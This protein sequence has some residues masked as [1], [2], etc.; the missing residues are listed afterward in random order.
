G[1]WLDDAFASGGSAGY[2]HKKMGITARGGWEAVKRHFREMDKDI[3]SEP[4]TVVGIG[5]MSG[6]VFGNGMLLSEQIKLVAAYDHRDIFIDP[7]PDTAKSFKE[8]KRL[9]EMG[10]S[11][12]QD[13][14]TSKLSKGGGI[15][16]RNQ[17]SIT[18]SKA[19]A[20]AI[21]L[22]KTKASPNEIMTAILKADAE[23]LWFG[24]IGTY[25]RATS[26]TDAEVGDRANDP[27]RIT[28]KEVGAKVIGEGANLGLTQR[29]RIEYGLAGGRCNSDA[30]DNSAGVNSSDVEVNIK[31]ALQPALANNTLPRAKRDKLLEAMTESVADLVLRTNYDQ[32][33]TISRAERA[34]TSQLQV[35]NRLMESLESRGL[36]NRAVEFLPDEEEIT[37]R[38]A[39]GEALTRAEIGVLLSYAK[40]VLF[41]DIVA[42][43]LP[44][45]PYLEDALISY[46]PPRMQKAHGALIAGHR[47]RR[48]IIATLLANQ[49]I[50]RGGT[51]V[52]SR[53]EDATGLLPSVISR[54]HV[55]IRDGLETEAIHAAIDAL[56]NKASGEA[57]LSLYA[58]LAE[59]TRQAIAH[60]L[61]ALNDTS[62]LAEAVGEVAKARKALA[63]HLKK[64]LPP[65]LVDWSAD[66]V[67]EFSDAGLPKGQAEALAML[68]INALIPDL[69][70]VSRQCGAE[71]LPAA[72]AFFEV[73]HTFKIGRLEH[74][75]YGLDTSDYFDGL[76][77]QRALDTIHAARRTLTSAA[78][79][80]AAGN[81]AQAVTQWANANSVRI[82]RVQDRIADLTEAG[83]LTASRLTVAAGLLSDLA[84]G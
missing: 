73:T 3:Q 51:S 55:V 24:G 80:A 27:I 44:D 2:D 29:A 10:R 50:N 14:D 20:D 82:K 71:V 35:Q 23:L 8:R 28:A 17:K 34:G 65:Y 16:P 9:F 46:F 4:F 70:A 49:V 68:P 62:P 18:L 63:S 40:L 58:E 69:V 53:F 54:A 72:K 45:D 47:L 6:D 38:M 60:Q 56:D 13:Y 83:E 30:I 39:K 12:W 52:I 33:L 37:E 67:A 84:E 79:S 75:A 43:D 42:S 26:E 11:S 74:Q 7:D 81:H 41:D 5:D 66:R 36:L 22:G 1:F 19:A 78:L 59:G 15:F 77:Q 25:I 57:Q 48:E 31:I 76:A 61:K 64:I 32:T 21:G